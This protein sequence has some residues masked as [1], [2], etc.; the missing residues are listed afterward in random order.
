MMKLHPKYLKTLTKDK[1]L[2][3]IE[4]LKSTR[5]TDLLEIYRLRETVQEQE[6]IINHYE[7]AP[8]ITVIAHGGWWCVGERP[9]GKGSE[10]LA[11]RYVR[12][13]DQPYLK[14]TK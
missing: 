6:N 8:Q 5:R 7:S 13:H 4:V 14:R 9:K 12:V 2:D 3:K 11:G 1:L 10:K